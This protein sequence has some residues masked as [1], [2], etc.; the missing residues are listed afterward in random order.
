MGEKET[1]A[2]QVAARASWPRPHQAQASITRSPGGHPRGFAPVLARSSTVSLP[3]GQ[4]VRHRRVDGGHLTAASIEQYPKA[5]DGA[6]PE[7]G[8]VGDC[9]LFDHFLD[10][11]L[12]AQQLGTGPSTFPNSG[13][14]SYTHLTLPTS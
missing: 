11:N 3:S 7:C 13:T 5:C 6:L 2:R 8:V 14:V 9:G 1:S 4:G 12:A 10:F